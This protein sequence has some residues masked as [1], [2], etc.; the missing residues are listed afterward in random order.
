VVAL[1]LVALSVGL[2]NFGAAAA[3]GVSGGGRHLRLQVAVVFG[4]FEAAMPL[5]GLL[6]GDSVA[7]TLGGQTKLV[8]GLVLCVAGIYALVEDRRSG[9]RAELPVPETGPGL[10]RLVILGAALSI[11][12]LA[13]GFA[14]GAYHVNVVVAAVVIGVVSVAL[15]LAGLELGRALG[16]RLG[17]WGERAGG[18]I[19]VLVGVSVAAG[20]L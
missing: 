8:A 11:D 7:R 12:N 6:L 1:V 18:V 10:R 20:V 14:L 19:L 13:I 9:E 2:D 17:N 4:V 5:V 16:P 15:T 3:L